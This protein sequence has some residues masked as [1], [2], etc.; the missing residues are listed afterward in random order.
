[1][2]GWCGQAAG[3]VRSSH[4]AFLKVIEATITTPTSQ[5]FSDKS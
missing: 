5:Y 4:F 3:V 2:S 1:M